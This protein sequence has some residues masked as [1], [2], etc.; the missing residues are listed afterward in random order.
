M[1][2]DFDAV[3]VVAD[4]VAEVNANFV[5]NVTIDCVKHEHC[6]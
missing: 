5:K 2:S 4:G 1:Q 6:V 3:V